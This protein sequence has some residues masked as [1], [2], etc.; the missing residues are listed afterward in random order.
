MNTKCLQKH[1]GLYV[2]D[3]DGT[4]YS[5]RELDTAFR[6]VEQTGANLFLTGRAGTGKTT[7]LN[8]LRECSDKNI[9]VLAPT[10]VAAINAG[11]VT[12][13]S[14][15]QFPFAPFVPGDG[16]VGETR[17]FNRF[18]R[19]KLQIIRG[20]D[21]LVI[22]EISMVRPDTLDAID[23]SLRLMR[24]SGRPFGGVQLLLIGD[25]RQLAPVVREEE[26]QML[27]GFYSSPY[28]FESI[29]LGK[30]G[31]ITVELSKVYRQNDSGFLSLLN[32]I[33][34]GH[35]DDSV[36]QALNKRYRASL[37]PGTDN[38][39][40]RLTTHNASASKINESKLEAI[41]E[42]LFVYDADITGNF[43]ESA[44]PSENRLFLK[45]G[46]QVMF[47]RNDSGEDRRF[48]NG[49]IATVSDLSADSVYVRPLDG[50]SVIKVGRA[51]WENVT[52][53]VDGQTGKIIQKVEG[54][55]SQIPLRLAWAI[56]IH[57]SQGLTFDKAII[58]A[59]QSFAP[60]QAYVALSRCRTLDGL[61]LESRLTRQAVFTDDCVTSFMRSNPG[62]CPDDEAVGTLRADYGRMLLEELFDFEQLS[63][64]F[65]DFFSLVDRYVAP[66]RPEIYIRYKEMKDIIGD[67]LTGVGRRFAS[68]YASAPLSETVY[69]GDHP[70][71][72]K[73][74]DG[75]RY[76]IPLI[77]DLGRLVESTPRDLEN[78]RFRKR[79]V[80]SYE[81]LS[82]SGRVKL[83]VFRHMILYGFT[84]EKYM[85]I[86]ADVMLRGVVK[87]TG[88]GFC[89][90]RREKEK[91]EETKSG[92]NKNR[93][94][95]S[96]PKGFSTFVTLEMIN[97]GLT[98]ADVAEERGLKPMT[99][100]GHVIE[101]VMNGR[102]AV[103]DVISAQHLVRMRRYLKESGNDT[104][105]FFTLVAES[106]S[107]LDDIEPYEASI[108]YRLRPDQDKEP[109]A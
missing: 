99:I 55:F 75:C 7:F 81:R 47:V 15:L 43:P 85:K 27:S 23:A 6:I 36:L 44:Y 65:D 49:M 108:V 9:V 42:E 38:G 12:I 107:G 22:D 17:K 106:N 89:N 67:R 80:D 94:E 88:D 59:G 101:L 45:K 95:K 72:R 66:S 19:E 18:N 33:R 92:N 2:E 56:T 71:Q 109:I 58:D 102:L 77:E 48:Y 30:A 20:L 26:W 32:S 97:R 84:P 86:K 10:G 105:T 73:I 31:F 76:F 29:A 28:F 25:L 21:L 46:A 53:S 82:L 78:T 60:G 83:A 91:A 39:Y 103:E 51:V 79:I 74:K 4:Y 52:F 16:F 37:P 11:G 104:S 34:E 24:G 63:R 93:K 70:L 5:N 14:F 40:I 64:E 35:P 41:G 13:H 62:G 100:A 98:I 68:L 61:L 8:R 54:T 87:N 1:D 90:D 3:P 50:R 69:A 57:K 96:R